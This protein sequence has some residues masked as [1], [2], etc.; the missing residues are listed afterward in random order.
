MLKLAA[1]SNEV[2]LHFYIL[3]V[4]EMLEMV[5]A[6]QSSFPS[7]SEESGFFRF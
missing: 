2:R 6:S 3:P 7:A 1:N 4:I 5:P